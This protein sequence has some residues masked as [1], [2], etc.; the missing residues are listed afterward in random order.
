MLTTLAT[1]ALKMDD[2][3]GHDVI[4][5]LRELGH[6]SVVEK[7]RKGTD[8]KERA[9]GRLQDAHDRISELEDLICEA[10]P[11]SWAS[12]G[13]P[14]GTESAYEWEKRAEALVTKFPKIA[15]GR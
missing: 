15:T 5:A 13:F 3:T 10:A 6:G 2:L 7:A 1:M 9:N 11:L 14:R 12:C 8:K 4:E